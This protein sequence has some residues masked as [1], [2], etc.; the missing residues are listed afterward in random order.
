MIHPKIVI[1]SAS[2]IIS[3][4]IVSIIENGDLKTGSITLI[5]PGETDK[6]KMVVTSESIVIVEVSV[7]IFPALETLRSLD[8]DRLKI[9][10]IYHSALPSEITQYFDQTISIYSDENTLLQSIASSIAA[11]DTSTPER[12]S[13]ELTPREKEIVVRVIK[14]LSNKEIA[15]EMNVS[16]HTVT[17]HRRNIASKLQIHSASALTIYAIVSN[18]VSIDDI[19]N[20]VL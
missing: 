3:A 10:G 12:M 17:T 19:K 20:V 6:L 13:D 5:Q 16:V 1:I 14:G 2:E 7:G 4:G 8:N 15:N 18:L 11:I 9:I